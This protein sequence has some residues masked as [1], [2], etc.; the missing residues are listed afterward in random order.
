MIRTYS[1]KMVLVLTA[2]FA[3]L[4]LMAGCGSTTQTTTAIND[5]KPT[6][7]A[8]PYPTKYQPPSDELVNG[9]VPF[10]NDYEYS[11]LIFDEVDSSCFSEVSYDI[12]NEILVVRFRDSGA[13]YYYY[14]ISPSFYD[15][16]RSAD[17]LGG[18]YNNSIKGKF[19]C[20]RLE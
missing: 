1:Q 9:K 14:K 15:S 8:S 3:I 16:F 12:N 13:L 19:S 7:T 10:D 20:Y 11:S 4:V 18:F 6:V 5:I 2:C 17:S